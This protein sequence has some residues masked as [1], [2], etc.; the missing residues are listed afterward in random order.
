[1]SHVDNIDDN[2]IQVHHGPTLTW[3]TLH[4]LFWMVANDDFL[5]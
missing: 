3:P 4:I 1:M 2:N 5:L